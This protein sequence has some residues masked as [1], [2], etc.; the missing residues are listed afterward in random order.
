ML[1]APQDIPPRLADDNTYSLL[2][3]RTGNQAEAFLTPLPTP[4]AACLPYPALTID[5][6]VTA[7]IFPGAD[8]AADTKVTIPSLLE[9]ATEDV[10]LPASPAPSPCK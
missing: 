8:R 1:Q 4:M 10:H 7:S 9:P 5:I 6:M 2:A 3:L